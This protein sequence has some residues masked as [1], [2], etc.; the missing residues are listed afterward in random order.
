M[1]DLDTREG[2]CHWLAGLRLDHLADTFFAEGW[3]GARLAELT[4]EDLADLSVPKDQRG[5]VMLAVEA[6][7]SGDAP[8]TLADERAPDYAPA[9]AARPS[10]T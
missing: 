10:P 1:Q 4:R 3:H 9:L 7:R 2:L 6:L 5:G 8:P